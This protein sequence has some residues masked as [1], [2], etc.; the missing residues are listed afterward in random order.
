MHLL[1]APVSGGAFP[2]Q[3]GFIIE[4]A[5]LRRDVATPTSEAILPFYE[6]ILASSGGNIATY[7][8]LAADFTLEGIERVI[9]KLHPGLLLTSWWPRPLSFLFPSWILGY[10]EGTIFDRGFGCEEA[11]QEIF[12]PAS[13][14]RI[15]VWTGTLNRSTGKAEIFCNLSRGES[16]LALGHFIP[17]KFNSMPLNYISRDL[18]RIAQVSHASA[19][20]PVM[21][22]SVK[23]GEFQYADGGTCFSSPLTPLQDCIIGS[24]CKDPEHG[25]TKYRS[26]HLDYVSSYN[27]ESNTRPA[28][29]RNLYENGTIALAEIIKSLGIQ[30]R[31]SGI[32]LLRVGE[33]K[34]ETG[35][36][37]PEVLKEI[38]FRRRH[39]RQSFLELYPNEEIEIPLESFTSQQVITAMNKARQSMMFRLWYVE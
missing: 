21:V 25:S 23:I 4:L 8:A 38:F 31:L 24:F 33:I 26:L 3:L 39:Y 22:P 11:F 10:Y 5:R 35:S 7:L 29:Y 17:E 19:A 16:K 32:E 36:C 9:T 15:E 13:V 37:N 27:L 18:S 34:F 30:D 20:I 28:T 6:A 12:T 14:G 1:I 2:V